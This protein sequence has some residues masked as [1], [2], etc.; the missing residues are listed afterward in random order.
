M[1]WLIAQRWEQLLFAH[2]PAEPRDVRRL[3]PPGVEPD[4]CDGAAWVAIVAFVMAGTRAHA[5]PDWR[6]LAPIPELNVRTYVRVDGVPGVWFLSLDTNSPLFVAMG[7]ALYGLR[8]RLAR[9]AAVAD[10]DSVHYVSSAGDAAFAS[11]HAPAGPAAPARPGSIED[12][13][14]ERYRLFAERRGRLITAEVAHAP[15]RLQPAEAE[16]RLNRMAPPG[17]AFSIAPLLHFCGAIDAAISKPA[18][19]RAPAQERAV[20][21]G[22]ARPLS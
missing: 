19:V 6:G 12:F 1:H 2:W 4:V 9:M 13:L 20:V 17:V 18:P 21:P 5:G 15:W 11:T 8:Y 14:F 22:F 16:I 3:L 7:R 10:G